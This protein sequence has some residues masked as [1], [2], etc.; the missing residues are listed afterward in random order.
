M[1]SREDL[2]RDIEAKIEAKLDVIRQ[3]FFILGEKVYH[4]SQD[5]T[6]PVG[7]KL[8]EECVAAEAR[9][10]EAI[11]KNKELDSFSLEFRGKK[12]EL[13]NKKIELDS[14]LASERKLKIK[15]GAIIFERSSL[16]LLDRNEFDFSY[17]DTDRETDLIKRLDG[18]NPIDRL[19][20][21][22]SLSKFRKNAN[23][24]YVSYSDIAIEKGIVS[25]VGGNNAPPVVEELIPLE[26]RRSVLQNEIEGL[27][28]YIG[29]NEKEEQKLRKN[30]YEEARIYLE[31]MNTLYRESI[32]S[33]G[34]YLF[35]KGGVWLDEHTPSNVLDS[36]EEILRLQKEY[37]EINRVKQELEKE[38]KANDYRFLINQEEAKI[39]ILEKEK[40]KIN[41]EI[42]EIRK[43]IDK[44]N[45]M[46]ERL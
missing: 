21:Q 3:Q 33:Y 20:A 2:E 30:G 38:S 12:T 18:R 41:Q 39:L 27:L 29:K 13:D 15:L 36:I 1:G 19:A 10:N 6:L 26:E 4:L 7:K 37:G 23:D 46:I 43:E 40:E 17:V 9:L 45:M 42:L 35:D 8:L 28:E 22:N 44:L 5:R 11:E 32:I 14:I 34:N 31:D 24:R 25:N 16:G